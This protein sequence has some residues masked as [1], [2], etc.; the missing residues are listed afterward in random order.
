MPKIVSISWDKYIKDIYFLIELIKKRHEKYDFVLGVARGGLF[1][2]VIASHA[3]KIPLRI[4]FAERRKI[5]KNKYS[6]IIQNMPVVCYKDKILIIDD[7]Y[8]EGVT[9]KTILD[10]LL[11]IDDGSE[12]SFAFV[13]SKSNFDEKLIANTKS[14]ICGTKFTKN[15][16][17]KY[18]YEIETEV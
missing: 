11:A 17:I 8:D 16:W 7:V 12:L 15:E 3:L 2:A 4:V 6:A 9:A 14:I 18:P 13:Y 1:P 10:E 5:A